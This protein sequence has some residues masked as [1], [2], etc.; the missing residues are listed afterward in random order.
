MR[1]QAKVELNAA[2][3]QQLEQITGAGQQKTRVIIHAFV[4]LRTAAGWTDQ[5]IAE[6][7]SISTRTVIRIRQRYLEGGLNLALYDKPRRGAPLHYDGKDQALIIATACTPAPEGFERWSIRL[8]SER[9]VQMG[10]ETPVSRET[11]RRTLKKTNCSL[12]KSKPGAC[13]P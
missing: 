3:R 8:L 4:L 2:D 6:A 13:Q 5:A 1:K 10:F 7:Y 9:S 12:T 11:I